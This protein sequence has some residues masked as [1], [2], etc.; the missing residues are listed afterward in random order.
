LNSPPTSIL[1]DKSQPNTL[2]V[3][4]REGISK[5]SDNGKSFKLVLSGTAMKKKHTFPSMR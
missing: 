3:C 1:A 5:S 4:N 2:Y